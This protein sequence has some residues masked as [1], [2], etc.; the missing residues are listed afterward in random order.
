MPNY[1]NNN[2][3]I[4]GDSSTISAIHAVMMGAGDARA[5]DDDADLGQ[6]MNLVPMPTLLRGT[7]SPAPTGVLT[8]EDLPP[9]LAS[10]AAE[11]IQEYADA[12]NRAEIAKRQTG[13]ADWYTWTVA[14]W[15]TKWSMEVSKYLKY[16]NEIVISGVTAWSPPLALYSNIS[17][18]YPVTILAEYVEEGMDFIGAG[19]YRDSEEL[20][21]SEGSISANMP[22]DF[23]WDGDDAWEIAEDVKEELFAQHVETARTN[24]GFCV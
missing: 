13:F 1:C 14:N 23:D 16:D 9:E 7:R 4:T 19:I 12:V 5:D 8:T 21:L 3:R 15:G 24:A 10:E 18:L 6:P 20:A 22:D 11:R 17:R 2:I